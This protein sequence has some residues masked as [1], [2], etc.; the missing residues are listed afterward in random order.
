MEVLKTSTIL[1]KDLNDAINRQPAWIIRYGSSLILFLVL[2]AL[3]L[4]WFIRY[5]EIENTHGVFY[6]NSSFAGEANLNEGP[7]KKNAFKKKDYVQSELK[8]SE[9]RVY[10]VLDT[11]RSEKIKIGQSISI[12]FEPEDQRKVINLKGC[13]SKINNAPGKDNSLAIQVTLFLKS[14][15]GLRNKMILQ[16]GLKVQ[17]A[18]ILSEERLFEAIANRLMKTGG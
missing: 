6:G 17:A 9:I 18:I 14:R 2:L 3:G 11:V 10:L 13:I 5:P 4:T 15:T 7:G 16:D 1:D 8:N 12:K